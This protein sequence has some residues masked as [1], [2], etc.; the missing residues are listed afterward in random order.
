MRFDVPT[1][2]FCVGARVTGRALESDRFWWK[3]Q[4]R[5]S[6]SILE[7]RGRFTFEIDSISNDRALAVTR[8]NGPDA[9]MGR[10]ALVF[11]RVNYYRGHL[12]GRAGTGTWSRVMFNGSSD[13]KGQ[14][15]LRGAVL[16]R[17]VPHAP[18]VMIGSAS[19]SPT[20]RI[21]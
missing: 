20:P 16:S 13:C 5:E 17:P 4:K 8:N 1:K 15:R 12:D 19:L 10:P 11:G 2:M 9:S 3:H 18:H 7:C 6:V 14:L 21:P